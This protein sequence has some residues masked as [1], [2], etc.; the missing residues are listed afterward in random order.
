MSDIDT[1][2]FRIVVRTAGLLGTL[3]L[4]QPFD[5]HN[6]C[7]VCGAGATPIDPLFI[8]ATLMGKKALDATAHDQRIVVKRELAD[9]LREL[10][11]SGFHARPV[12]HKTQTRWMIDHRFVWLDPTFEWP[13]FDPT[14]IVAREDQCPECHRSGHFDSVIP[15]TS[16][17]YSTVP[18][19]AADFGATHEY[20]GTW[21]V[22]GKLTPNI[23]GGRL[24]IVSDRFRKALLAMKV[25]RV[26][27]ENIQI[28]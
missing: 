17:C 27:F 14:S 28:V 19:D 5:F 20:Y 25:K 8:N 24:T 11:L 7:S 18:M 10:G 2:W 6:A 9:H 22:P 13:P 1:V 16:I 23:G 15:P 4:N 3:N 26:S 21:R 12:A